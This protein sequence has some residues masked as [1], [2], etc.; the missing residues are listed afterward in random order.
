[1]GSYINANNCISLLRVKHPSTGRSVSQGYLEQNFEAVAASEDFLKLSQ[2]ELAAVYACNDI[3][4]YELKLFEAALTW[5][6]AQCTKQGR[7][8]TPENLRAALGPV[9]Q[10]IRFPLLE[11]KDLITHVTPSHLL[12][13]A[14]QVDV[15]THLGAK[16]GG[17]SAPSSPLPPCSFN[18]NPR[19]FY[20]F[21]G[22]WN[23][24]AATAAAANGGS[25]FHI[26]LADFATRM[27][28]NPQP[29][30]TFGTAIPTPAADF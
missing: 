28:F 27:L 18:C 30:F 17:G 22:D 3:V 21:G 26:P 20:Q 5:A 15:F 24:A 2:A 13:A 25:G 10:L 23:Q 19:C 4:C 14:E 6:G 16:Q 29:V 11:M 7:D 1:M 9:I 12:T 8:P